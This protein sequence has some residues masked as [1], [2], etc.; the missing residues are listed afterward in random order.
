MIT[1][2]K[3]IKL[4]SIDNV[5]RFVEVSCKVFGDV[6]ISNKKYIVDGKSIMGIFSLN[7]MEPLTVEY[8]EDACKEFKEFVEGVEV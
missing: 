5:K 2:K 1:C 3:T 7:L 4:S 6:T 8:P